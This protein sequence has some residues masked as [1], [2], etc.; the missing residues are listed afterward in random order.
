[1]RTFAS[2]YP[3]FEIG[4]PVVDQISWT[5]N[6]ILMNRVKDIKERL[7]YAQKVLEN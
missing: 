3:E 5:H 2:E 4:Q 6:V 7:R 1:M